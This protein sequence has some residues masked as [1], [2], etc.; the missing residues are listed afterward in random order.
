MANMIQS[1]LGFTVE[2]LTP[3]LCE[4]RTKKNTP[5]YGFDRDNWL[6]LDFGEKNVGDTIHATLRFRGGN[7]K[8]YRTSASCG[9]TS[10]KYMYDGEDI[11]VHV[12][13]DTHKIKKN[14]DE[15]FY[16][17]DVSGKSMVVNLIIN[18]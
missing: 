12:D 4:L 1:E 9:C 18:S 16:L 17:Y 3:E 6:V 15:A 11:I 14:V 10:P 8:F 7:L 13:Y 2:N 5:Y